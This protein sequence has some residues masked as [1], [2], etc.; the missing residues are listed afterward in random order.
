M[1]SPN[2]DRSRKRSRW[3]T[4]AVYWPW[5]C[6][7]SSSHSWPT[8][9]RLTQKMISSPPPS[10]YRNHKGSSE[11]QRE[12]LDNWVKWQSPLT[13]SLFFLSF[14]FSVSNRYRAGAVVHAFLP[15]CL[16]MPFWFFHMDGCLWAEGGKRNP[17]SLNAKGAL[18]LSLS[19]SPSLSPSC[20][21]LSEVVSSS[22]L[23]F[24]FSFLL[25]LFFFF[26]SLSYS[27]LTD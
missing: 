15:C 11:R 22:K 2:T 8:L 4:L 13:F 3:A 9:L 17:S 25:S 21:S 5:L 18:S 27:V 23:P 19:C 7:R 26:K 20:L 16:R 6:R 12:W 1:P 10:S 14:F 24:I